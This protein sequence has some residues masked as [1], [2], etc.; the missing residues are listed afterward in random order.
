MTTE[1]LKEQPGFSLSPDVADKLKRMWVL[2]AALKSDEGEELMFDDEFME[3]YRSLQEEMVPMFLPLVQQLVRA[4]LL[5]MT[6]DIDGIK[7]LDQFSS[8]DGEGVEVFNNGIIWVKCNESGA[9]YK[10]GFGPSVP[11]VHYE[12]N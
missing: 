5:T 8:L 7:E 11:Q 4:G 6:I 3:E 10:E 12:L 1:Q 9:T 2:N